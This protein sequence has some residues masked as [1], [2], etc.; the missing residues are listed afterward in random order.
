[1]PKQLTIRAELIAGLQGRGYQEA[2]AHRYS[3]GCRCFY[4]P[5]KPTQR[6]F[7]GVN[8]SFRAGQNRLSSMRISAKF[9]EAILVEGQVRLLTKGAA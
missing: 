7:V 5:D 6:I 2:T 8:G 1:M 9:T 4:H 3:D